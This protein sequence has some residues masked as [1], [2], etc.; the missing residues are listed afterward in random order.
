M[1]NTLSQHGQG[2]EKPV[3]LQVGQQKC[4]KLK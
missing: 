2:G 4:P 1:I 3:N